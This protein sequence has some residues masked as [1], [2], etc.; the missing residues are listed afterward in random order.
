MASHPVAFRSVLDAAEAYQ[1]AVDAGASVA[2]APGRVGQKSAVAVVAEELDRP[3]AS[4]RRHLETAAALGLTIAGWPAIPE[5][6]AAETVARYESDADWIAYQAAAAGAA[7]PA[8][9]RRVLDEETGR[10][11][12]VPLSEDERK[13]HPEWTSDDCIAELQRIANIDTR[14]VIT[15]NYFRVHS[16]ISESTWNR[17]FGTFLE[18]KRQAEIILSR[19][20]HRLELSIAK[21]ASVDKMR[22]LNAEKRQYEGKYLRPSGK[23]WQMVLHGCDLHDINCDPFYRRTFIDIARRAQPEKIVI[24]GDLYDLPEF[25]K[26]IQDPRSFDM[27]KR[28]RWVDAFLTDLREAAPNAEITI[29]EG[30]HEFRLLRHMGEQTPAMLVI[31]AELHGFTI[32]KLLGL[33]KFEV[34]YVARADMTAWTERDIKEQLR[35]NYVILWKSVLFGHF[36]EFRDRGMPGASGHHHS[37][38]VWPF[39]SPVYGPGEWHQ[40]GCGHRREA[41]YTPGEKWGNGFLLGHVDTQVLRTQW[42]YVDVSHPAAMIGGKLYVRNDDEPVLDLDRP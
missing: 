10:Y 8:G 42:E 3:A 26:H 1:R 11:K 29:V 20:A 6:Q 2:F 37:H 19:H 4:V 36:P 28:I 14:K 35:K 27:A 32:P 31:L 34:N 9:A 33:D 13:F 7:V 38:I 21:H 15:R 16:D 25:S 30:N 40:C 39:Y 22:E 5:A 23:R 24:N 12:V 18:F 17:Y 41:S